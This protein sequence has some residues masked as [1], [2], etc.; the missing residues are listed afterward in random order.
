MTTRRVPRHV[1]WAPSV[2]PITIKSISFAPLVYNMHYVKFCFLVGS[3]ALTNLLHS[4]L[5][6]CSFLFSLLFSCLVP[7]R[8][9]LAINAI[10]YDKVTEISRK[11]F[12]DL[13]IVEYPESLVR[14]YKRPRLLHR[15]DGT[16]LTATQHRDSYVLVSLHMLLC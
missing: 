13:Y 1:S 5:L 14:P 6:Q 4:S 11:R 8:S 7:A 2:Q 9:K 3:D 16:T 10:G 12:R 15:A